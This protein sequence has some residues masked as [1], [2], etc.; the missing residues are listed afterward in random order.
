M[1]IR[2]LGTGCPKCK[3]LYENTQAA[4]R[5]TGVDANIEKVEKITEIIRYGVITPALVVNDEVKSA[6]KA[7]SA[8]RISEL[9]T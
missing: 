3:A 9:L 1:Q 6:G 7:L 5:A 8:D 2:I 4:V